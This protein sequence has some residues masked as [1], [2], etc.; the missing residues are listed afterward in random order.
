METEGGDAEL[1]AAAPLTTVIITTSPVASNP[2]T[3]MLEAVVDSFALVPG[4]TDCPI[5]LVFDGCKI[6]SQS[7][8]KSGVVTEEEGRR[9]EQF[10]GNCEELIRCHPSFCNCTC[11]RMSERVGFGCAVRGAMR[12]VVTCSSLVGCCW[13]WRWLLP[14]WPLPSR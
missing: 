13:R 12:Q 10:A 11:L 1:A 5:I 8:P 2:S 9:Y 4:L 14:D 6:S 3:Q 7:R